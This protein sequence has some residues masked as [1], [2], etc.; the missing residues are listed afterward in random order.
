MTLFELFTGKFM[1][2]GRSNNHLLKLMMQTKGK[3]SGKMI[4]KGAF[5]EQHFNLAT[6]QFM[7]HEPLL[8]GAVNINAVPIPQVP[9]KPI[10]NQLRET[11]GIDK[12]DAREVSMFAE[13][14]DKCTCIDPQKRIT[15]D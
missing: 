13:F 3:I 1:F 2:P 12:L 10:L 11:V 15:A 5:A 4:K 9:S 8:E 7:Q 6:N 14:L